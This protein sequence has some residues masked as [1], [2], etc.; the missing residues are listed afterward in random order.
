MYKFRPLF[1][2]HV[3]MLYTFSCMLVAHTTI[4]PKIIQYQICSCKH[5]QDSYKRQLVACQLHSDWLQMT[6][7]L[8]VYYATWTLMLHTCMTHGIL[9][10]VGH[11][12]Y[13]K[14]SQTKEIN[15]KV[16]ESKLKRN[17]NYVENKSKLCK[18]VEM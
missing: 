17:W 3:S 2:W 13:G 14:W 15:Y 6:R 18:L 12:T 5:D 7:F 9:L 16:V 1:L 10:F 4:W 11:P 8:V